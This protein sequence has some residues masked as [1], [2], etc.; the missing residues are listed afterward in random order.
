MTLPTEN[1]VRRPQAAHSFEGDLVKGL[2]EDFESGNEAA[3]NRPNFA[4]ARSL[5]ID[6]VVYEIN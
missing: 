2:D 3:E 5:A 1:N 6:G 4:R